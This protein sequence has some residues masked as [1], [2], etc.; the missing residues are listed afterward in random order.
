VQPQTPASASWHVHRS[1][2]AMP[3]QFGGAVV[4]EHST[5][6]LEPTVQT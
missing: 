2:H 3:P 5:L 1:P 4:V 6:V